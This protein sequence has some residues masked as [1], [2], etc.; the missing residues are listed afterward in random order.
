[1][2]LCDD[3]EGAVGLTEVLLDRFD[4]GSRGLL[5][6]FSGKGNESMRG[7]AEWILFDKGWAWWIPL[8]FSVVALGCELW[9]RNEL[10]IANPGALTPRN[11]K[12][13]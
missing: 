9:A 3:G 6:C 11:S 2:V 10:R 7:N 13:S 5:V 4:C 8:G 12:L 1:M